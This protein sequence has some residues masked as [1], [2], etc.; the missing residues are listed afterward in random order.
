[1]PRIYITSQM[2]YQGEPCP[3]ALAEMPDGNLLTIDRTG[4]ARVW[5]VDVEQVAAA[6]DDWKKMIGKIDDRELSLNGDEAQQ[7]GADGEGARAP[8]AVS[9]LTRSFRRRR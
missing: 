2:A 7:E 8:R 4:E 3:V 1:M 9:R 6:M 5:Q